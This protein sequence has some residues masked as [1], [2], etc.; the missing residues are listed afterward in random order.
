M[1]CRQKATRG[2]T[3]MIHGSMDLSGR[4]STRKLKFTIC[5]S[6][7]PVTE[8]ITRGLVRMSMI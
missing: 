4:L 7:V 1:W 2:C 5:R 8:E 3:R 6:P